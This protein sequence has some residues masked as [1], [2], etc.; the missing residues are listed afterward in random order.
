M[1]ALRAIWISN[2]EI[3]NNL[4]WK[5]CKVELKFS[6]SIRKQ[7]FYACRF[8]ERLVSLLVKTLRNILS[9]T[10]TYINDEQVHR[11][12]LNDVVKIL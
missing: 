11:Q 4:R 12:Y 8:F 3:N 6:L 10:R 9:E 1:H 5:N 2:F 7:S